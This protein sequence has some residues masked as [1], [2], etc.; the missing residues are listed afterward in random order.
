MTTL[1]LLATISIWRMGWFTRHYVQTATGRT[2]SGANRVRTSTAGC[3][4]TIRKK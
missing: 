2:G 3:D 4:I 1:L